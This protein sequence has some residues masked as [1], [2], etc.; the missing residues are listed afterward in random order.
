MSSSVFKD[1]S[2]GDGAVKCLSQEEREKRE[3]EEEEERCLP[4]NCHCD[5]TSC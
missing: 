3:E 1:L 5:T 4:G 2:R